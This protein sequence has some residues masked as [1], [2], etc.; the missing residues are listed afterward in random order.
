MRTHAK[1]ECG[2]CCF[3]YPCPGPF[4]HHAAQNHYPERLG[5]AVCYCAPSLFSLTWRAT[6]P[7]IDP[8]TK[9]K[10]DF[11]EKRKGGAAAAAATV[12]SSGDAEM[13]V[14][15]S[16]S[17]KAREEPRGQLGTMEAHFYMDSIEEC[18]GGRFKGDLFDFARYKARMMVSGV[19]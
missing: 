1:P 16:G 5:C 13:L 8:V 6:S 12:A 10:I 15:D 2:A 3:E 4:L 18:M 7:F 11:V 14:D 9:K 19:G 17:G